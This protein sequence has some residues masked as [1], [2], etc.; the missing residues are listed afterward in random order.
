[1][2]RRCTSFCAACAMPQSHPAAAAGPRLP[3]APA[4]SACFS[5][6]RQASAAGSP[7]GATRTPHHARGAGRGAAPRRPWVRDPRGAGAL[8]V[9]PNAAINQAR[10]GVKAERIYSVPR[11]N[12]HSLSREATRLRK[13]SETTGVLIH[14]PLIASSSERTRSLVIPPG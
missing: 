4:R 13:S 8:P 14:R 12:V 9:P 6:S 2:L 5:C 3:A 7:R 10:D 11:E 1:M